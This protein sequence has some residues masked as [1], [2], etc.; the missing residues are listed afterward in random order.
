MRSIARTRTHTRSEGENTKSRVVIGMNKYSVYLLNM[1]I[2]NAEVLNANRIFPMSSH[3]TRL[4]WALRQHC[5]HFMRRLNWINFS[6]NFSF[7]F[8]VAVRRLDEVHR[9]FCFVS[10]LMVADRMSWECVCECTHVDLNLPVSKIDLHTFLF[11]L[12]Q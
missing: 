9:L 8:V 7:F 3:Y 4:R 6:V 2:S 12:F 1:P 11:T 5:V 10:I